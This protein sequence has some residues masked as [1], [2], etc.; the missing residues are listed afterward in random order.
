[1]RTKCCE[2]SLHSV[3]DSL[4]VGP[5]PPFRMKWSLP[6]RC[7]VLLPKFPILL[8]NRSPCFCR[9]AHWRA[10]QT[11]GSIS[12]CEVASHMSEETMATA[13]SI[14]SPGWWRLTT[15]TCARLS[16]RW[17]DR[18]P[19]EVGEEGLHRPVTVKSDGPR[20]MQNKVLGCYRCIGQKV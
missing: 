19:A 2:R 16:S 1:M 13:S 5:H 20:L 17:H 8:S 15:R 10:R 14:P 12:C 18:S 11:E 7:V 3:I 4:A 9:E 6:L